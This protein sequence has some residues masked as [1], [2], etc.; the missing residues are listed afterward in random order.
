VG[1]SVPGLLLS[2]GAL[3]GVAG[4]S[5]L[6]AP[7]LPRLGAL[8]VTIYAC[9]LAAAQLLAAAVLVRLAGG[10]P[11]LRPLTGTE[12]AAL[13]YL[14][15]AV[16]AVV[17]VAWFSAVERLG[18][19]RT[20]LFSGLVPI[21]SLIAVA[22]IGT[23]TVTGMQLAGALGVLAGVALGLT[24]SAGP[25]ADTRRPERYP[26]PQ[27]TR[28]GEPTRQP[29]ALPARA[30]ADH[31][32]ASRLDAFSDRDFSIVTTLLALNLRAP[33]TA[34]NPALAPAPRP[35]RCSWSACHVNRLDQRAPHVAAWRGRV[36]LRQS[37]ALTPGQRRRRR[38]S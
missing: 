38:R 35:R 28:P 36:G 3:A 31:G 23:G 27:Q 11:V 7:L 17:F 22:V 9:G 8:T 1:W 33:H 26:P 13:L 14:A 2:A 19:E 12:L 20:G 37:P 34:G 32:A 21:A 24:Q 6:A 10:P 5:L 15:V 18:V 16:T 29:A 25:P 30:H 4:T